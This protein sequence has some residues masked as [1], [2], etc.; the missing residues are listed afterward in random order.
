MFVSATE[1]ENETV[2]HDYYNIYDTDI[3]GPYERKS[4][5][6]NFC[7]KTKNYVNQSDNSH[8]ILD[9]WPEGSYRVF[10]SEKQC[11]KGIEFIFL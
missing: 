5:Q 11:P 1:G 7:M 8:V 3:V 4:F 2:N 9:E 6:L 10:S